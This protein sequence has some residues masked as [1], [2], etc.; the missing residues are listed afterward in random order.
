MKALRVGAI[1][2]QPKV[3][4]IPTPTAGSD[5]VALVM[6]AGALNFADLLMT[7]GKYQATP[8]FPFTLGLEGVGVDRDGRR[9]AVCGAAGTL[10][11]AGVFPALR[12]VPVPDA[13]PDEIVAGMPVAY[14]TAH[15][16]L[17]RAGLRPGERLLVTGAGGGVGLAAVDVGRH[18]GAT[19]VAGARG[20]VHLEAARAAGAAQTVDT[21]DGDLRQALLDL[22][23]VDVVFDTVGGR[24]FEAA[25]RAVTPGARMLLIGFAGGDLPTLRPNHMLVKNVSVIGFD[26]GAVAGYAPD[27]WRAS[28]AT[29]FGW[30]AAGHLRPHPPTVLPLDRAAEAMD[31][32]RSRKSTGKVVLIP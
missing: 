17:L 30:A 25:F 19:V 26:W 21:D 9:V 27:D 32:I 2:D 1:G 22:G 7:E 10:A 29:V 4:E 6:R 24:V 20:T 31:L 5:A 23:R 15:L 13:L 11:E 12:C 8:R 28:L 18:M 3:E 16:G 14:G